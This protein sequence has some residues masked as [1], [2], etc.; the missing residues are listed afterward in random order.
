MADEPENLTLKHLVQLR[1]DMQAG[2]AVL[3]KSVEEINHKIGTLAQAM[4]SMRTRMDKMDEAYTD[5]GRAYSHRRAGR[6]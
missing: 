4:T 5:D 3:T 2:F 6:R 1:G